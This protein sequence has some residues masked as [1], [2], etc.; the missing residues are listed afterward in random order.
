MLRARALS[1]VFLFLAIGCTDGAIAHPAFVLNGTASANAGVVAVEN[2]DELCSGYLIA[3]NL[4]LTA[5]HCVSMV[6]GAGTTTACSP[7]MQA[8]GTTLQPATPVS[9]Y[10]A[11][12]IHVYPSDRVPFIGGGI[13]VAEVIVLPDSGTQPLCGRDVALVRL[14]T[15]IDGATIIAP[16]LDGPPIVGEPLTVVGYGQTGGGNP[17]TAGTRLEVGGSSPVSIGV[18][19]DASGR[20][21]T[22]ENEWVID[23]GPCSGDSGS[24]AIDANGLSVG[25]MSRGQ[26]S[27][28]TSMVYERVDP[29][30]DWLR[31]STL[32]AAAAAGIA[33]P[34]WAASMPDAGTVDAGADGGA[35]S[36]TPSGGCAVGHVRA[37]SSVWAIAGI[38][39]LAARARRRRH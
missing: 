35:S 38:A 8:D 15:P 36:P 34:A 28:C 30:A 18:T 12:V 29:H 21:R 10:D 32:A 14:V 20:T 31:A 6:G 17:D 16:R 2:P 13:A 37:P 7:V 39:M 24:P 27:V 1:L 22:N 4:V 25:V 26:G 23:T 3:P 9:D 19:M 11:S 33:P 5:R